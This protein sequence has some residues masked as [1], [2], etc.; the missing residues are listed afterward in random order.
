MKIIFIFMT[1]EINSVVIPEVISP[2][3]QDNITYATETTTEL[4]I[5]AEKLPKYGPVSL[6]VR[7]CSRI[8]QP[9]CGSDGVTYSNTCELEKKNCINRT[10][11]QKRCD[12]T[13]E[14]CTNYISIGS[15]L[16]NSPIE[17]RPRPEPSATP[18]PRNT[19]TTAPTTD[20]TT[21]S[22]TK[23][24]TNPRQVLETTSTPEP[25]SFSCLQI[26]LLV[27]FVNFAFL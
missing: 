3:T 6:C 12:G 9:I 22:T 4:A 23:A 7:R 21:K 11:Y 16:P 18:G 19:S 1:M 17:D 10:A 20:S 14:N 24:K 2:P 5:G 13:C 25:N 26:S 8:F 15:V 27:F